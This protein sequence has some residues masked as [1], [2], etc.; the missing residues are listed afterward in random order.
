MN[1]VAGCDG[2]HLSSQHSGGRGKQI[3]AF[4]GRGE[5][6]GSFQDSIWN[7]YQEN[8]FKKKKTNL[9]YNISSKSARKTLSQKNPVI[10]LPC[11]LSVKNLH[12][13]TGGFSNLFYNISMTTCSEV[14]QM[15][16]RHICAHTTHTHTHTHARACVCAHNPIMLILRMNGHCVSNLSLPRIH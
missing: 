16:E 9:V 4:A 14:C 12:E 15:W 5:G 6:I 7:V 11:S 8:I 1:F 3:S 2:T 13:P 10:A